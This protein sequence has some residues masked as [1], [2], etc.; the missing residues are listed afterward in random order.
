ME[1]ITLYFREGT[2]DKVY[3]ANIGHERG[4]WVVNFAYGRRGATL[5]SG[6]KTQIPVTFPEATRIY[7]QLVKAKMAKGYT[8]GEDG[9]PY[10]GTIGQK[11]AG[12]RPQLLNSLTEEEVPAFIKDD[13]ILLQPK[14]DGRRLL[15]RKRGTEVIGINRKGL[16]CGIPD[17]IRQSALALPGD[18][19]LDGEAVGDVLHV[20]DLLEAA[21]DLR[22]LPYQQRLIE[23]LN[24]L[25]AGHHPHVVWVPF[26]WG[27]E[28]A[29]ALERL[30]RENAEGVV[31]K[32]A[33]APYTAGRPASGGDQRKFKFVESASVV[34]SAINAKRSAAIAVLE[35]DE[36]L[37][38]GNVAIPPD[39]GVPQIGEV[40]EVSYL[41]AMPGSNALFQPVYLGVR[42]DI[43][44]GECQRSQFKYKAAA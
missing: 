29:D 27:A 33:A 7:D 37:P 10:G 16:E 6:T 4:G 44:P 41:Y 20:F 38:A 2:A 28:K 8:P 25:A 43:D 31:F 35:G 40:V 26:Y 32:R 30:R 42:G 11:D 22:K 9:M 3:M 15:L 23:L 1:S 19:L 5:T 21:E 34:V 36:F 12:I 13:G 24:L 14:L 18:F 39:Q 17:S